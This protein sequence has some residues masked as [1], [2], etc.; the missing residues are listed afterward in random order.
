M[1]VEGDRQV[2][3]GAPCA[4]VQHVCRQWALGGASSGHCNAGG[5]LLVNLQGNDVLLTHTNLG[6]TL[7]IVVRIY[8]KF[9]NNLE[10]KNDFTK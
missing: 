10:I 6:I 2:L 3:S 8:D 1:P 5:C 9:D 7:E 4:G